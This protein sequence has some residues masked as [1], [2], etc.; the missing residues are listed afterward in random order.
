MIA[1]WPHVH[2][3]DQVLDRYRA[4]RNLKQPQIDWLLG[5]GVPASAIAG[6]DALVSASVVFDERLSF[7]DEVRDDAGAEGALLILQYDDYGAPWDLVGWSPRSGR[8]ASWLGRAGFIGDANGPRLD[9]HGGLVV[10]ATVLQWLQSN[11]AGVCIVDPQLAREQLR[12][13]GPFLVAGDA[14]FAEALE[15]ALALPAPE[16]YV[17]QEDA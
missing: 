16:I 15:A 11:R 8:A 6:P 14:A 10:H 3:A 12:G 5:H 13:L 9:V 7:T 17:I 1:L 2:V 4:C